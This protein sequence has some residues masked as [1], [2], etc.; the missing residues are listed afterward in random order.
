[1]LRIGVCDDEKEMRFTL[2][3]KLERLLEMR[4]VEGEIYEFS[5][6]D[7]LIEWY[8]KHAGGLDLLFL[9]IEMEGANGMET[10][11]L[12]RRNDASLQMVFVT[13]HPDYV[14]AG[15]SVSALGYLMK[16]PS[17]DALDDI[18]TRAMAAIY[19]HADEV[20]L[21]RNSEGTY[22]LPK[23]SILYFTSEKRQVTCT[24]KS[25]SYTFY[26]KL[27]QVESEI[28]TGF[29]R[30]HQRHLVNAAAVEQMTADAVLIEG[31][32]LPISRAYQ[33]EAMRRLTRALLD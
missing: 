9:D 3:F 5:L 19:L 25:G 32:S 26:G 7:R 17:A 1:M 31:I 12:L 22:R 24:T 29:I 18:L 2:R 4:N 16:P 21:C 10:A 27:S 28:G 14:F 20:Y 13:A 33:K 6:G 30:I 8:G 23:A 15:Y 11:K